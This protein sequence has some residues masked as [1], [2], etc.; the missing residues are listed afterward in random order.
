MNNKYNFKQPNYLLVYN[1][2]RYMFRP[3]RVI[4]RSKRIKDVGHSPYIYFA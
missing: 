1:V 3:I 2:K 4:I